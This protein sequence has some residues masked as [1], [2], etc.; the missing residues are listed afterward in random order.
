MEHSLLR[1]SFTL[2]YTFIIIF[3]YEIPSCV[4]HR[5]YVLCSQFKVVW[6]SCYQAVLFLRGTLIFYF[7]LKL[8]TQKDGQNV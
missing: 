6:K 4:M 8:Y 1:W 3:L 7:P 5:K 2:E